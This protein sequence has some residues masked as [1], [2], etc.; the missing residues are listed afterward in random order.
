[1]DRSAIPAASALSSMR[2]PSSERVLRFVTSCVARDFELEVVEETPSQPGSAPI[3]AVLRD[4]DGR[5]IELVTPAAH[6]ALAP[7]QRVA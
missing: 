2:V 1:M 4:I 5:I 6:L 3:H 7:Q